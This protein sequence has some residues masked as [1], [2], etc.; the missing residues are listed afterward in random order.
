VWARVRV[1]VFI[2]PHTFAHPQDKVKD[3]TFNCLI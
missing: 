1:K 3:A 2:L